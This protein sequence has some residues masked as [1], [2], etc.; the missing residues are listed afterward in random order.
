[1]WADLISE[2]LVSPHELLSR[3]TSLKGGAA[4]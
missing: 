2:G 3:E 4:A 1:V